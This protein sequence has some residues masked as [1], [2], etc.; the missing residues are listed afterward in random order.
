MISLLSDY[1]DV[2]YIYIYI[3]IYTVYNTPFKKHT[4]MSPIV[5]PIILCGGDGGRNHRLASNGRAGGFQ[6]VSMGYPSSWMV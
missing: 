1:I 6:T 5:V 4:N 2:S 3:I